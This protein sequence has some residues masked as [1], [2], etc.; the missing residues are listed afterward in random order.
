[1]TEKH[2]EVNRN[3]CMFLDGHGTKKFWAQ[4]KLDEPVLL[5]AVAT[6]GRGDRKSWVKSYK[7]QYKPVEGAMRWKTVKVCADTAHTFP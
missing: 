3:N 1:M 7:I 2:H 6:V 4:I 5:S